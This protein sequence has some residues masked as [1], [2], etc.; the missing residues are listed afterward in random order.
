MLHL[1]REINS[2]NQLTNGSSFLVDWEGDDKE[3]TDG[4]DLVLMISNAKRPWPDNCTH[5]NVF[6]TGLFSALPSW[7]EPC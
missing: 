3:A 5:L 1:K 7:K 2:S 4:D 6:D